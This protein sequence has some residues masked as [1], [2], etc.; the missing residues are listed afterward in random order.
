MLPSSSGKSHHLERS[1]MILKIA[2]EHKADKPD[3]R[4]PAVQ[5]VRLIE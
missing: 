1:A 4:L 2:P 3:G 5:Q